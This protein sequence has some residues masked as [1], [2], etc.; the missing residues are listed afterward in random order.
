MKKEWTL[1]ENLTWLLEQYKKELEQAKK[2]N[3]KDCEY[4]YDKDQFIWDVE[5]IIIELE[6]ALKI[7]K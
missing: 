3:S 6:H 1:K 2:E 5:N 7:S 4:G